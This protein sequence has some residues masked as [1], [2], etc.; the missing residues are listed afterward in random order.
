MPLTAKGQEILSNMIREYGERKGQEVFY[1]SRNAG[2]IAG[3]DSDF[4]ESEHPRNSDGEFTSGAGSSKGKSTKLTSTEKQWLDTYSGDDF[5][6]VNSALR[7]GE[8]P[9]GSMVKNLDSAI[10]KSQLPKGTIV[11]R[12]MTRESAKK[13]FPDGNISKGMTVSDPGYASTSKSKSIAESWG[14]GGVLL[15][16]EAGE[17]VPGI[18]MTGHARNKHEEEVLLPRNAKM[19][20]EGVIAP[21]KATDPVIVRVS[22]GDEGQRM[23]SM[24]L[25]PAPPTLSE[26]PVTQRAAGILFVSPDG[27]VLLM[28]RTGHD[29]PG[30][31]GLPGGGIEQGET[32]EEAARRE[33][34]E[35]T[36]LEYEGALTLWT[37]RVLNGVDFTTF[38]AKPEKPF[39][40][41]LNDEHDG[42]MWVDRSFAIAA[43]VLL[44]P[45]IPIALLRFD[46][47]ELGIAK[48]IQAGELTSPQRY[49]NLMLVAL[50]IT[51]TGAAYRSA[52]EE[53]VWRDPALYLNPEFLQRCQGLPV[54][55]VHPEKNILDTEEFRKRIIGTVMLPYIQGDEVWGIAK[56]LDMDAAQLLEEEKMS[57]SPGVLTGGVKKQF[58]GST[59]LIEGKPELFDH[60]A[61]VERGV[62]DK[63][64]APS[65]VDSIDVESAPADAKLDAALGLLRGSAIEIACQRIA[66]A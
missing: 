15:K 17:D 8:D 42:S 59:L 56:I 35:E 61:V 50:R 6:R 19:R 12:G 36:G 23:D 65:G 22:Y 58:G 39:A 53:F 38:V 11:Y 27:Q 66:R 2:T 51:G 45:G 60:L 40:P 33:V 46:M 43:S 41:A 10:A 7:R 44:H 25:G 57:T 30:C 4:V 18:D 24:E 32:A 55:L 62:W 14:L 63:G 52:H 9:G 37:R 64:G 16:I 28:R 3:V 13:L 34:L 5:L 21:K 29:C 20:V 49:G 47:D 31:W 54:I 26:I 1:A 48:A